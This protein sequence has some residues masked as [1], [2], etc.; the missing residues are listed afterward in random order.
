[1]SDENTIIA[2][3]CAQIKTTALEPANEEKIKLLRKR[4]ISRD[5]H[6]RC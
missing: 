2:D 1:M 6:Q 3:L 5:N 4:S